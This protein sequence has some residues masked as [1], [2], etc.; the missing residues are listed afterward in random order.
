MGKLTLGILLA[1]IAL[2]VYW[3]W[4]SDQGANAPI[5]IEGTI[6]VTGLPMM[7]GMQGPLK[8]DFTLQATPAK[9]KFS[10]E[11]LGDKYTDIICPGKKLWHVVNERKKVYA[12]PEFN[13]VDSSKTELHELE[14]TWFDGLRRTAD[15]EYIGTGEGK[16][17]C[18]KQTFTGIPKWA[19]EAIKA[20]GASSSDLAQVEALAKGLKWELWFTPEARV[21]RRY[22]SLL[23]KVARM[24]MVGRGETASM[25]DMSNLFKGKRPQVRY[26]NLDYFPIPMKLVASY[27]PRRVEMNVE[28]LSREKIPKETFELPSGFRKVDIK[29]ALPQPTLE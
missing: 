9:R 6:S 21:G 12:Q 1:A 27:G 2:G 15:W 24:E 14:G 10:I 20:A 28:K 17:F 7:P 11:I 5:T 4:W 29:Q 16:R 25:F 26:A 22:F 19:T 8:G 3:F 18:N 23:N 13:L